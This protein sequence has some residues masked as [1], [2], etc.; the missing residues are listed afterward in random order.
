MEKALAVLQD[1]ITANHIPG[2]VALI[3]KGD[4]LI[5]HEALG[6]AHPGEGYAMA[7]DTLFDLASLTKVTATLPAI[8]LLLEEGALRLDDPISRFLPAFASGDIRVRHLLTH[9]SGLPADHPIHSF[10]EAVAMAPAKPA[11]G[12]VVYSD[13]GFI[14]LGM[15]AEQ[16]T[17]ERLDSFFAHR[18]A[19]P[20]GM[21]NTGY[22][23]PAGLRPRIAAT[24]YRD[25]LGAH[26]WGEVH[27]EKATRLGGVAGHAGLFGTAEDLWLYARAWLLGEP[28]LLS[29]ASVRAASRSYTD[30]LGERRG[31]GWLLKAE[32]YASCGDLFSSQSYGH[33][34]FTGTSLWMDPEQG[35]IVI[36]LT[37][38]VYYG[39]Q[40]HIIR[41]RPRFHN[42]VAAALGRGRG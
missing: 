8:M 21:T 17:G 26:Q 5:V 39:R 40:D 7:K 19:A 28:Y 14:L 16:V 34:G 38:R 20:L 22:R 10:D 24:E 30:P 9:T 18:V 3:A 2:A 25:Y 33:T 31:L 1:A 6:M 36:L 4:R 37:N 11:G 42:A 35:L 41:L 15:I 13:I 32:E 23:P 29:R 27:D 12:E